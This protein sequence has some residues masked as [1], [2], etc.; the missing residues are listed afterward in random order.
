LLKDSLSGVAFTIEFFSKLPLA[1]TGSKTVLSFG[2]GNS[3]DQSWSIE[4]NTTYLRFVYS[5]N[6]TGGGAVGSGVSLSGIDTTSRYVHYAIS[7][8]ATGLTH[9][10]ADGV[11]LAS[12]A[13]PSVFYTSTVNGLTIG[14]LNYNAYPYDFEGWVG[15]IRIT[16]TVS[17]YNGGGFTPPLEFPTR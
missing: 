16:R 6:G 13:L 12:R 5:T 10:Y 15:Q 14:R 3:G 8:D 1:S 4:L 2:D 17:R 7:R 11:L 9:F